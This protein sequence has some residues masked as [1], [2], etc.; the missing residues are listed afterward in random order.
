MEMKEE[1][2]GAVAVEVTSPPASPR[3][4]PQNGHYSRGE[5]RRRSSCEELKGCNS[6]NGKGELS[7]AEAM[8]GLSAELIPDEVTWRDCLCDKVSPRARVK[9]HSHADRERTKTHG[10][11]RK[12]SAPHVFF[13]RS[14]GV[15]ASL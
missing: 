1:E 13:A 6:A 10:A 2:I 8:G 15:S 11:R 5:K 14:A 9:Q 12:H 7:A 4:E 3:A